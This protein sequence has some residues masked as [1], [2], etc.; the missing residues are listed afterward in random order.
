VLAED[1][2]T[3]LSKTSHDFAIQNIFPRLG[4]VRTTVEIVKAMRESN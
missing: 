3:S 1:A 2:M 4:R